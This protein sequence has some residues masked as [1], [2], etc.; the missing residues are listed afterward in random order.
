MK[1]QQTKIRIQNKIQDLIQNLSFI[2]GS[3]CEILIFFCHGVRG[4]CFPPKKIGVKKKFKPNEKNRTKPKNCICIFSPMDIRPASSVNNTP[5]K[6]V[7][8]S[9]QLQQQPL[10]TPFHFPYFT[11]FPSSAKKMP[12]IP[13]KNPL[14]S[15]EVSPTPFE[16]NQVEKLKQKPEFLHKMLSQCENNLQHGCEQLH[17]ANF[18][19][20]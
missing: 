12:L 5:L 4:F 1:F 15:I 8:G 10:L 20:G 7:A 18:E 14:D 16:K 13:E 17:N 6:Q 2:C 19:E 9:L 11:P 3:F